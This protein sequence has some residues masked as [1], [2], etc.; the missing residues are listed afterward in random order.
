MD[1]I[2]D[3]LLTGERPVSSRVENRTL[4]E[5]A[6]SDR[7]RVL[8]S[9]PF[10]RMQNKAQVFSLEQ[11]ASVRTRLSHTLEVSS[12][13]KYIAQQIISKF[14][15]INILDEIG[16]N[17]KRRPFITFIET[18]CLLHDIGNPPFGH[19]GEKAI[20]EWFKQNRIKIEDSMNV[21]LFGTATKRQWDQHYA[22]LSHFDGNPQGFRIV[23]SLQQDK[24]DDTGKNRGSNLSL[25]QL[26]S[27]I[28]Y[29]ISSSEAHEMNGAH[30]GGF[31]LTESHII[32]L[33]K[34]K[35]NLEGNQRHP[36]VNVMEASDDIAYC[37]SDLE[38]GVEKGLIDP[39]NF[40]QTIYD[41]LNS[42]VI[43]ESPSLKEL[44]RVKEILK[45]IINPRQNEMLYDAL[46]DFRSAVIRLMVD[47]CSS[48]YVNKH[49]EILQGKINSL[50]RDES[51]E[52]KLLKII[53]NYAIKNLYNSRLVRGRELTAFKV[54]IGL[55]DAYSSLLICNQ[56]RFD[57]AISGEHFDENGRNI[58][59][60]SSL[61]SRIPKKYLDAYLR[62]RERN[63]EFEADPNVKEWSLRAHLIIDYISGMTDQ[64]ALDNYQ[65]IAGIQVNLIT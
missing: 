22:D 34:N 47:K 43:S 50:I 23:A 65:L 15:E 63:D 60:E 35:F 32:E 27:I 58:T 56:K 62:S 61:A 13:G 14:E 18:A 53:K 39:S 41:F 54:I 10:R 6:D 42:E 44:E 5:E 24:E 11:N 20:C 40:A 52:Y 37:L 12:I 33:L 1:K 8:F 4:E 19:F 38:D 3:K 29:P 46:W 57:S 30:K 2:Y 7:G 16:L 28:K 31:F 9:S 51:I 36:L 48:T 21:G 64:Y 49:E 26:A 45:K 59:V 25:T 17:D 55:L